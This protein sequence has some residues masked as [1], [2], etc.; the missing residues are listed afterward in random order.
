MHQMTELES[1]AAAR[2]TLRRD[3]LALI[4]VAGSV[5]FV[6]LGGARL[7]DRDEPRNA[8]CAVEMLQRGDWVTP[9][10]NHELRGQKPVLTYWLM[11]SAITV[12]GVNEFAVRFWSAALGVGTVLLTYLWVRH[13]LFPAIARWAGLI[14]STTLMFTLASRAATPDAP[15]IFCVSLTLTLYVLLTFKPSQASNWNDV[16]A[17]GRADRLRRPG[18]WFPSAGG[19][20]LIYGAM[21]LGVLAKGPV[22][23]VLPTLMIGLFVLIES[24]ADLDHVRTA[25]VSNGRSRWKWWVGRTVSVAHPGRFLRAVW[26]MQPWWLVAMVALISLPWFVWVG[27][28]TEGEFLELFFFRE[29]FER[30]TSAMEGHRG[31]WWFYPIAILIGVFP[32]SIL[33]LPALVVWRG[34]ATS[35]AGANNLISPKV[36]QNESLSRGHGAGTN[37]GTD[38]GTNAWTNAWTLAAVWVGLQVA[39]FSLASTK[40]PS[41]VTPCYPAVALFLAMV[42]TQL[43]Q[44][45][46][47]LRPFWMRAGFLTWVATGLAISVGMIYVFVNVMQWSVGWLPLVGAVLAVGGAAAWYFYEHHELRRVTQAMFVTSWL[48]VILAFG[49][50][51]HHVSQFRTTDDLWRIARENQRSGAILAGY[52]DLES[53]WV[54]YAGQPIWELTPVEQFNANGSS[55]GT[56]IQTAETAIAADG[57]VSGALSSDPFAREHEWQVKPRATV[58]QLVQYRPGS[59]IVTPEKHVAELLAQLPNDYVALADRPDFL[60][61]NR[62]V[63]VGPRPNESAPV[64]EQRA[65]SAETPATRSR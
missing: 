37:A 46:W 18:C 10:F 34:L 38:A 8:G 65:Q 55:D 20:M 50:A 28:R 35:T 1:S 49:Y 24:S 56:F 36:S 2:R 15:L 42:P 17:I 62:L 23:V 3:L 13:L 58:A 29:H 7:W 61:R 30:A 41:Y 32:W 14:L 26:Q 31:G 22:A 39:V 43:E 64:N 33:A 16:L 9:I 57:T 51:T 44:R 48:F 19:A 4:L 27:L 52:R 47:T 53:T 60:T 63:L 11:M 54:Y 12:F 5:F 59:L 40:L 45:T 25:G 21:A 6:N